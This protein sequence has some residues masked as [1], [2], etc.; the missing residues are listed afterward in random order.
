MATKEKS[1]EPTSFNDPKH[2]AGVVVCWGGNERAAR[3]PS[4]KVALE[5]AQAQRANLEPLTIWD[6]ADWQKDGATPI[7][8]V[9]KG[10]SIEDAQQP[11]E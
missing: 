8:D 5:Q 7:L 4:P 9:S 10:Q 6:G 3:F 2:P 1:D 11:S